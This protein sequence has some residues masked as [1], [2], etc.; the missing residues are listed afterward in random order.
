M[1]I[2]FE[3]EPMRPLAERRRKHAALRD[4]AGMRRSIH[5]AAASV[6]ADGRDEWLAAWQRHA[7]RA[8]TRGYRAVTE[9]AAFL[10]RTER[11]F[12]R[13]VAV[14]ELEKAAYEIVY[15]ANNRPEWVG[16]PLRGL[17]SAAAAVSA[18]ESV[19]AA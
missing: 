8:F 15:E 13:A 19:E 11:A 10:P 7:V 17:V 12:E 4:V 5:Y 1:L 14:F 2:D 18:P 3:G 16:I 9:G 6:P